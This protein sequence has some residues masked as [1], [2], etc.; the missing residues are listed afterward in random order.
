[1]EQ[2]EEEEE[3][4]EDEEQEGEE[5]GVRKFCDRFRISMAS[6]LMSPFRSSVTRTTYAN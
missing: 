1:M 3:E 2:E 6:N 5:G 4:E